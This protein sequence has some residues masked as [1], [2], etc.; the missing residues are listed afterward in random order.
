MFVL[1][2]RRGHLLRATYWKSANA[3][4][5]VFEHNH[6]PALQ[7]LFDRREICNQD[8]GLAFRPS[9][10]CLPEEDERWFALRPQ[11]KQGPEIGV[12]RNDDAIFVLRALENLFVSGSLERVVANMDGIVASLPEKLSDERRHGVVDEKSH[13]ATNGSSRSRTAAAAYCNASKMSSRSRSG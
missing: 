11:R 5:R 13:G 7:S 10:C 2:L 1:T 3:K 6:A 8:R 12:G 4:A 9:V